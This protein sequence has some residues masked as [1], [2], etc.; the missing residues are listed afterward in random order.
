MARAHKQYQQRAKHVLSLTTR[1]QKPMN[2]IWFHWRYK[3][4]FCFTV[5]YK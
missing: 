2:I 1:V 5:R 3:K 4:Q